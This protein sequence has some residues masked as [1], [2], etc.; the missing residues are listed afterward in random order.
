MGRRRATRSGA[1][2]PAYFRLVIDWAVV[3]PSADAPADLE[4]AADAA[5]CARRGPCLGWAGVRDQLRA[6]ASRQREGGWQALV[7]IATDAGLGRRAAP[8]GCER[9]GT[10]RPRPAA[11]RRRAAR[12]PAADPRRAGG[13]RARRAPTLRFWSAVERAEP[14]RVR[15]PA[16]RRL[17][18]R[19]AER[20]ARRLR[21]ARPHADPGARRGARR[22]AARARRDRRAAEA[23]PLRDQRAGVHRRPPAGR[24]LRLDGL[25]PARLHRRRRPGRG[26]RAAALAAHGC[27]QPHTIWITETGVG[28]APR[29]L[30]AAD[31]IPDA[32]GRLPRAPRPARAVVATTRASPSPS[33]TRCARTTSSRPASSAPT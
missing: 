16:A 2:Q 30:S 23:D 17:R 9:P 6:L 28:A 13:G 3:Q 31:A 10:P 11:A 7:V 29:D 18:P 21:R 4:R 15:Q 27:P 1:I 22:A 19:L 20:R 24:R 32:G 5:A 25:D 26:G 8:A 33:S 12:L 14:P